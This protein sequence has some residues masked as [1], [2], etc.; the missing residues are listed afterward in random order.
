MPKERSWIQ[1]IG[2]KPE[3]PNFVLPFSIR[4]KKG[5]WDFIDCLE[6]IMGRIE[7]AKLIYVS[8]DYPKGEDGLTIYHINN[9][10]VLMHGVYKTASY[11]YF[12][13]NEESARDTEKSLR[14]I[15]EDLGL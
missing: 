2:F 11:L 8:P 7:N 6:V 4:T 15:A 13:G 9:S 14:S 12:Y 10:V 1:Q 3:E 5:N